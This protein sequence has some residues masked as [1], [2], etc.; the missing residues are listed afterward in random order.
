MIELR[1][2]LPER[3][4]TLIGHYQRR[5]GPKDNVGLWLDK[6]IPRRPG[7]WAL[8]AEERADALNL[9]GRRQS[10]AGQAGLLRLRETVA[11][12]HPGALHVSFTATVNGRL[13]VDY[14]RASAIEMNVSLHPVWGVPRVPGS[15]LKG[16]TRSWA[17]R[18]AWTGQQLEDCFGNEPEADTSR[19]GRVIFYDAYPVDGKFELALDVL[20]PHYREY[21][22]GIGPPG[23]YLSPIP[24]T[25]LTVVQTEFRFH[26]GIER[27]AEEKVGQADL[28]QQLD[29]VA[30]ALK[31]ALVDE[32]VGAKTAAGYGRFKLGGLR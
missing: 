16:V 11:L 28:A 29:K 14:G 5:P 6:L 17:R 27:R 8:E 26:L 19:A 22:E 20:T 15:A 2:P 31:Q 24:H 18:E 32:G 25:F 3:T 9:G 21:Y 10:E 30:Q 7:T 4:A 13:L 23:E 1:W 12:L